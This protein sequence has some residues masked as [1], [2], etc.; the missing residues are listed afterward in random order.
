MKNPAVTSEVDEGLSGVGA[1]QAFDQAI[2]R[3]PGFRRRQGQRDMAAHIARC[4]SR[5]DEQEPV[6]AIAVIQ[7]GTGVGKSAA[8][9]STAIT[10]ALARKKRLVVS[11]ATVALQEQLMGQDLPAIAAVMDVPFEYALAKGRTRY[12]CR[13]KLEHLAAGTAMAA[14]D[15]IDEDEH[16]SDIAGNPARQDP[17]GSDHG[18]AAVT[19]Y[20]SW[21]DALNSGDWDGDKDQLTQVPQARQWAAVAAER[22]GCTGR[23]CPVFRSCAYFQ[24]R[25]RLMQVQVIVANH[26]LVLASI[27]RNALP[28][29]DKAI[30]VF[31][32]AH[33]LPAVALE[34]FSKGMSLTALRWL[35]QLPKTM[36]EASEKASAAVPDVQSLCAQLKALMA[37]L[38]RLCMDCAGPIQGA[39]QLQRRF[40]H[41]QLP[42]PLYEPL[43]QLQAHGR[44]L[45]L[46][47]T[48]L[49]DILRQGLKDEPAKTNLFSVL[50]A[51]LGRLAGRLDNMLDTTAMLLSQAEPPMAKW[52]TVDGTSALVSMRLNASPVVP[53][54][55]LRQHLWSS[56]GSGVLTSASLSSCASFDF[57][58][59][60]CGLRD[61]PDVSTLAVQS[62]F[63][64]Q[65]QGVLEVVHTR[66]DPRQV[67]AYTTELCALLMADLRKVALGALVLFTSRQQLAAAVA[68]LPAELRDRV[69]V[70][71]ESSRLRLLATHRSRVMAGLPSI[72]F[73]LQSFGEGLDLPGALCETLLIAKLPFASPAEPVTQARSEWIARQGRDPFNE[74]VVPATGLRLLQWTGRAIRSETDR[75][76]LVCYDRRLLST[77]FGRRML[78]GLPAY[79][80]FERRDNNVISCAPEM[81]RAGT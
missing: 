27:G 76:R 42:A 54:D 57:F 72:L 79:A 12:V 60:E 9:L 55:L 25:S 36:L 19:P 10:L 75:A 64:Y 66:S 52:I 32:E 49:G 71:G 40:E 43:E 21:R 6:A 8:Y 70:Q 1:L 29:L 69:L 2:S 81:G 61:R 67:D 39:T 77:S 44:A 47:L 65:R 5:G 56:L 37:D 50:Y 53:G 22:H 11:T 31:D 14:I 16:R 18:N 13:L 51:R 41:G 7:A 26:D 34:Q 73:G 17:I 38:A 80:L 23:H 28:E 35:D 63:D 45:S 59:Q 15:L 78:K 58:L 46:A 20:A 33:H 74:L 30:W 24:A 68:A 62:P 48:E 3:T 4:L